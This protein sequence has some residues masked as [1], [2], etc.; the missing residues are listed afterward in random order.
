MGFSLGLLAQSSDCYQKTIKSGIAKKEAG[1]YKGALN[2]F[3]A[4]RGCNPK[5]DAEID[6][7]IDKLFKIILKL[8]KEAKDNEDKLTVINRKLNATLERLEVANDSVRTVVKDLKNTLTRVEEEQE[9][10]E[11]IIDAFYFYDNR[12]GL[13]VQKKG[14]ID[15]IKYGYID[16]EG[17][18]KIDYLYDEATPFDEYDGYALVKRINNE[19]LL[20]T[21]KQEYQLSNDIDN[22]D[23][24]TN[25]LDLRNNQFSAIPPIVFDQ[26]QLKILLLNSNYLPVL[27]NRIG[28]LTALQHLDL[29]STT[30]KTLPQEL[31][32]LKSLKRLDLGNNTDLNLSEQ[33]WRLK[34]LQHLDLNGVRLKNLPNEIG[35]LTNLRYLDLGV[36]GLKK[37]PEQMGQLRKLQHLDLKNDSISSLPKEIGELKELQFLNLSNNSGLTGLPPEIGALENLR[38]LDLSG[39]NI[40]RIP[41][42]IGKLKNLQVMYVISANLGEVPVQITELKNLQGLNLN[43]GDFSKLEIYCSWRPG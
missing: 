20:D 22:L 23:K 13:V 2:L 17:E 21:L 32:K 25:A 9:K 27:D 5:N 4:A 10:N 34:Q 33:I 16:K 42:E 41:A 35:Q 3:I 39:T 29:G 14:P 36:T 18:V 1:D 30:L 37:M 40:S 43:N 19:Y 31:E 7:E 8:K 11:R 38:T 12:F 6:G 15:E 26:S 24:N 28:N